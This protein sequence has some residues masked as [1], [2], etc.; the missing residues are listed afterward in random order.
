M[1]ETEKRDPKTEC[2]QCIHMRTIPGNAN[3]ECRRP[4]VNMVGN[5]H[6][7]ANGWFLYPWNFD[8]IWK[9]KRCATFEQR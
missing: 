4:D 1:K 5:R 3:I 7:I 8:P 9:E 2:R 6:G